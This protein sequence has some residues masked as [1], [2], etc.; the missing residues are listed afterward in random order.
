MKTRKLALA[1]QVA[2]A[3]LGAS[4]LTRP[5]LAASACDR[6][7]LNGFVEKYVEAMRAHDPK[8]APFAPNARY[9]E[10]GVELPLPD[11]L[12]RTI[13]SIGPYRLLVTDVKADPRRGG[14]T[15]SVS[16]RLSDEE[17]P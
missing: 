8:K 12:W 16:I 6:E 13:E 10:N 4:L 1:A 11:G 15:F 14:K 7:C 9:T 5:A 17:T 2:A 3:L